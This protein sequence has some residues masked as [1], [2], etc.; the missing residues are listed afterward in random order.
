MRVSVGTGT[1]VGRA[2]VGKEPGGG[3]EGVARGCVADGG[4][5]R[6]DVGVWMAK[7]AKL[8]VGC[9]AGEVDVASDIGCVKVVR[10]QAVPRVI[11]K[12]QRTIARRWRENGSR[13]IVR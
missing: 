12:R 7:V 5:V 3:V 1:A 6:V 4:T 2:M 11:G 13:F 10:L 8:P 9:R